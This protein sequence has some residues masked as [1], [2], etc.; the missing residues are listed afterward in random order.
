[1]ELPNEI[2]NIIMSYNSHPTSDMIKKWGKESELTE[3]YFT[4]LRF[5]ACILP[6]Y[7]DRSKLRPQEDFDDLWYNVW[8]NKYG[9]K[10]IYSCLE[11]IG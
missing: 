1:M 3:D 7:S 6:L 4:N 5:T 2:V 10:S 11:V 8:I 9:Q